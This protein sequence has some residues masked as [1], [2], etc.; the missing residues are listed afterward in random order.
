M[1]H[2]FQEEAGVVLRM[3]QH[4]EGAVCRVHHLHLNRPRVV[5]TSTSIIGKGP[6]NST[7]DIND[8][9]CLRATCC[10]VLLGESG[11][12]VTVAGMLLWTPLTCTHVRQ[13]ASLW[14]SPRRCC[15]QHRP[16]QMPSC[17][18]AS[19]AV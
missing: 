6:G 17:E 19:L 9:M 2:Q 15:C 14:S 11:L 3:G 7:V 18:L 4:R 10:S 1:A 8:T 5:S 13:D 16:S 12:Y